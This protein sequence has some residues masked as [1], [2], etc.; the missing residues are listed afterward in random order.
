MEKRKLRNSV[1]KTKLGNKKLIFSTSKKLNT[2]AMN[3][4]HAV[5]GI[6]T[7]FHFFSVFEKSEI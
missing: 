7:G 6:T 5:I 4:P 3:I 2:A 1:N